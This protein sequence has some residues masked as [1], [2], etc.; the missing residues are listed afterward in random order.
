MGLDFDLK[1]FCQNLKATKPPY[2]CPVRGCG[3]VY[4]SFIGIQSHLY[5]FDHDNPEAATP[6][7]TPGRKSSKGRWNKPGV[8][9]GSPSPPPFARSPPI[10]DTL[11]YAE[12]QRMVQI[13]LDGH[14]Y[15]LN[16]YEPLDLIPQDEID[17]C[18]NTEKE[19]GGKSAKMQQELLETTA[20]RLE[21]G[22]ESPVSETPSEPQDVSDSCDTAV[23]EE[24]SVVSDEVTQVA[25]TVDG[26]DMS[27]KDTQDDVVNEP[28]SDPEPTTPTATEGDSTPTEAAPAD[29]DQAPSQDSSQD[30]APTQNP[31]SPGQVEDGTPLG[32]DVDP[33]ADTGAKD[34]SG[35]AKNITNSKN[36]SGSATPASK[37][38]CTVG[39]AAV[40]VKLPPKLPEAMFKVIEDYVKPPTAPPRPNAY[41]RF[42]EKT[43]EE[44][45]EEIEYDM[46]EEVVI[47]HLTHFV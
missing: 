13:D 6:G 1:T 45:D 39:K 40:V 26:N 31:A 4:K 27:S 5:N 8:K 9:G 37:D 2:E 42:I 10:R 28:P 7:K 11:T 17:N 14:V 12:S 24:V 44:L 30:S 19:Q 32:Q 41:Y 20:S 15:R 35:V 38:K 22:K 33:V 21:K 23:V 46:D 34:K 25:E 47:K 29:L 36:K 3:K 16:I 18:D 43:A